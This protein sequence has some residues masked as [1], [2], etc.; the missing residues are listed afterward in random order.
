GL[1]SPLARK[2]GVD[3]ALFL[4]DKGLLAEASTSNIFLVSNGAL[5]TPSLKSGILP[6][7]T[8]EVILEL[9]SELG[10]AAYEQY[11]ELE[12]LY[13]AEEAFLINSMIEIMPLIEVDGKPV[14]SGRPGPLTRRLMAAY[15]ELVLKETGLSAR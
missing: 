8:R 4:N 1:N 3:D 11:A 9:A 15:R 2:A 12:E 6:G 5:K 13:Q 10:I 14:G 7:I